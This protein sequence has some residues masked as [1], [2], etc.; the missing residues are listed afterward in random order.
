MITAAANKTPVALTGSRSPDPGG[1]AAALTG[2]RAL[3][4][5][6]TAGV[7]AYAAT[8]GVAGTTAQLAILATAVAVV[9]LPHGALDH[10][11]AH[12]VFAP[13]FRRR[14]RGAFVA[15]YLALAS[16]MA[17]VWFVTPVAAL[18]LFL[19]LS[20]LHFGWDDPAWTRLAGRGW[21][22]LERIAVGA[23]PIVLP[24][25]LHASEV[26]VIFGWLMPTA[27]EL[28]PGIVA[29][30]AGLAAS[31]VL[32]VAALRMLRLLSFPRAA[33][34]AAA[35]LVALVALHVIAPPL[36]AF[37]TFFCGWHSLRHAL[38]L[39]DDLAPGDIPRG[40]A[41]FVRRALPLTLVSIVGLASTSYVL[42]LADV[43]VDALLASVIFIGL[44][45]LTVPHMAM[46]ALARRARRR[47]GG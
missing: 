45:V 30:I 36:I 3:M 17:G 38:E 19:L 13:R 1:L 10:L 2:H 8:A 16:L 15:T 12:R 33:P 22:A 14:W 43:R 29:S 23:L 39:A 5:G 41:L 26:T 42:Y 27:G 40:F 34:A 6:V 37:L 46:I 35:E 47:S 7:V 24:T 28:D 21:D 11:V 31:L 9:G 4:L 20:A 32:P 18:V 25:W 44:S